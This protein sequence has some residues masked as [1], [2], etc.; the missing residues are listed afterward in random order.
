MHEQHEFSCYF[1]LQGTEQVK[2]ANDTCIYT[3]SDHGDVTTDPGNDQDQLSCCVTDNC[4]FHSFEDALE[5]VTSNLV[6][7]IETSVVLSSSFTIENFDNILIR[8][9]TNAT[10]LCADVGNLHFVS[11]SNVTIEGIIWQ[12]CGGPHFYNSSN[13]TIQDCY[14]HNST[15]QAIVMSEMSGDVHFK[16]CQ[17]TQNNNYR[18]HGST[19]HYSSGTVANPPPVLNIN[20]C[21]FTS[22]GPA[23]SVIYIRGP[24]NNMRYSL[25]LQDSVFINNQGVPIYLSN[26]HVK[27]LGTVVIRQN[28]ANSGGGIFST[29]SM[30]EFESCSVQFYN[31]SA[32]SNGGAV[33][34][35]NSDMIFGLNSSAQFEGNRANGNGGAL[36][37]TQYSD[38]LV[39]GTS[40][41]TFYNNTGSSGGAIYATQYSDLLVNGTS[42]VTFYNNTVRYYGGAIYTHYSDLLV[43][44]TSSVT[45]YNNTARYSGGAIYTA[46][47]SDISFGGNAVINFTNNSARDG[48]VL[49]TSSYSRSVISCHENATVTFIDN[50][51]TSNGG[52]MYIYRY[53]TILFGGNSVVT[54]ARNTAYYG[55]V[56]Y[57]LYYMQMSFNEN[58]KTTFVNNTATYQ[59][60]AV[61]IR[62]SNIMFNAPV[63]FRNN[64]AQYGRV[65]YCRYS[66]F[67]RYEE[68]LYKEI[69][70]LNSKDGEDQLYCSSSVEKYTCEYMCNFYVYCIIRRYN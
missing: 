18:G 45:F 10:V 27:A 65:V 42:S 44:G 25:L 24:T 11:C 61:Y 56:V 16:D 22:N 1:L 70:N 13:I 55:G 35:E 67:L 58:T 69:V 6:I 62:Y 30:I 59:G 3:I 52:V 12:G 21:S 57:A 66:S 49:Y 17:F 46:Q 53:A 54:F 19:I 36:Y 34:L 60:G 68:N 2:D 32:T 28:T 9:Q 5:N 8:S 51:A 63:I 39:N 23:G 47:N 50:R 20:N 48:G 43:N 31:N 64:S 29:T 15:R 7:D 41:V 38:F 40:S 33:Y 14:F 37:A 4:T 26:V